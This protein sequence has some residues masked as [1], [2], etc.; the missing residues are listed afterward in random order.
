MFFTTTS[1]L[2]AIVFDEMLF[3]TTAFVLPRTR[4]RGALLIEPL[5]VSMSESLFH[6]SV[7]SETTRPFVPL[8]WMP[9][10]WPL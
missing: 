5:P 6:R 9:L 3:S 8:T 2:V 1:P 7:L 4:I 10:D